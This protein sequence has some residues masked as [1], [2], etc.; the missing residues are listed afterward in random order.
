MSAIHFSIATCFGIAFYDR[1]WKW[2]HEIEQVNSSFMTPEGSNVTSGGIVW[3]IPTIIFAS[4]GFIR[5]ARHALS[6]TSPS[7]RT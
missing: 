5:I 6:A 3:I 4:F 2:R 1:F 7:K